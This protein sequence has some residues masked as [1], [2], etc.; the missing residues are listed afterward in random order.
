MVDVR[1]FRHWLVTTHWIYKTVVS[2]CF[3]SPVLSDQVTYR[4]VKCNLIQPS[5]E[6][7][8]GLLSKKMWIP[9]WWPRNSRVGR[10]IAKILIIRIQE[11]RVPNPRETCKRWHKLTWIFMIK[12]FT[13]SLPLLPF[14]GC[15]LVF[16]IFFSTVFLRVTL[17]YSWAVFDQ[18]S[19]SP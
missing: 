7:R 11:I 8:C 2:L 12:I 19:N 5:C 14:L 6:K 1:N 17:F 16:H 3:K 9:R 15:H 10:P 4:E 18:M 13:I